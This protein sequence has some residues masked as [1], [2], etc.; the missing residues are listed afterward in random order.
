MRWNHS[1]QIWVDLPGYKENI[2]AHAE[3]SGWQAYLRRK[4]A[5]LVTP[6]GSSDNAAGLPGWN[7]L[8]WGLRPR[9]QG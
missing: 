5:I 8:G 4:N 7:A 1:A 2:S 6:L 9:G 3:Y